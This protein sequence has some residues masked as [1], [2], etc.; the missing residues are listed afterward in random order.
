MIKTIFQ[1]IPLPLLLMS[2]FSGCALNS[3]KSST[4]A[5][6]PEP[7]T[8]I[9]LNLKQ[10]LDA[11]CI[12]ELEQDPLVY[13]LWDRIR[14]IYNLPEEDNE[15]IDREVSW[16]S[17]H[18]SYIDRVT[19]RGEPYLHYIVE[20]LDRRGM[21]GELAFLPIVE[22]AFDPF[23]YSPGR[24]SG[25]WQIIPG[26]GRML[27]LKQSWWY[28]GRRDV[29]QST[30]AALNYLE[31]LN[32]Q[33]D[34]DWL[35]AL[36]AYNSGAGT[37]NKAIRKNKK[38]GKPV[39]YWNLPLPRETK[40]YVPRLIALSKLFMDPEAHGLT[41]QSIEDSAH[42]TIVDIG[43]QI[44]LAQAAELAGLSIEILYKYNPGFNRWATDPSG[45]HKLVIP[46]DN[47]KEFQK[48]L[49]EI[50]TEKRVTWQRHTI[51]QGETLSLI[52]INYKVSVDAL[53][54]INSLQSTQI[55]TGKT[56]LVPIAAKDSDYYTF[57]QNQRLAKRQN[58]AVKGRTKRH[59]SVR[60]G[61]SFW[62][63][64]RKNEVRVSSLA[65]WN[66]MAPKDPLKI[67]QKLVI[68]TNS[69]NLET[70]IPQTNSVIRRLSYKVRNGDSLHRIA[71][72]F[73]VSVNDIKKWNKSAAK[74]YLQPGDALILFV[75]VT[76][77]H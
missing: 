21:P 46:L 44:D 53:K 11:L 39:D 32:K 34:G 23:A 26:T 73:K 4:S 65:K 62:S 18:Q 76:K 68:W 28:D 47:A 63:I 24:A 10:N 14:L 35:L 15:R 2:L 29:V 43:S 9:Q 49:A 45:P 1:A 54:R 60:K 42:F 67:G 31:R 70:D 30:H 27:G 74:K 7:S 55:R 61:D 16:F 37:V 52:A 59:Y 41:L 51:K 64:A 40:S 33:F 71:D 56:L 77:G 20:E 8:N 50:P 69:N 38:K 48:N 17:R 66:G 12:K 5:P 57:S 13:D 22:S 6:E 72:K 75:D 19:E 58:T 3:V 25:M 36:A